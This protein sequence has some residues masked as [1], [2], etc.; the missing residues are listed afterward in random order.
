VLRGDD[1]A[2]CTW[3][4]DRRRARGSGP[5][6]PDLAAP[7]ASKPAVSAGTSIADT[8][9]VRSSLA[10]VY[11]PSDDLHAILVPADPNGLAYDPGDDTLYLADGGGAV[12]AIEHGRRRWVATIGAAGCAA[13]QLGGI[14]VAPDGTLYV[15]R[16]GHG[17]AGAIVRITRRGAAA[18]L[19]GLSPDAW[20]LGVVHDPTERALYTTQ[21]HKTAS[22]PCDGAVVRIDLT[23]GDVEPVIEGLG[24]PVGVAKLGSTLLVTD[25][26]RRAVICAELAAGHGARCTELPLGDRPDSIAACG[27]DS[28]VLTSYRPE[29]GLGSVH[30]LWL[31]GTIDTLATGSW[32]PRGIA[33]DGDR[34]FVSIRRGGR[35]LV[36]RI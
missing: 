26:R 20:R 2:I 24:K 21:Y 15:A 23:T 28:V 31:D 1:A 22:G 25:A 16:L 8:I 7:A 5:W 3:V 14:A 30:R 27:A 13:D 32:Q 10:R 11:Q 12:L 34:A 4:V 6:L 33:S 36:F 19:P 17:H 9:R 18:E 29:A 35:V